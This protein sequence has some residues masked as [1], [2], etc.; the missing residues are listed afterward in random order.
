MQPLT[1]G[2][3]G[4]VIGGILLV[5][6]TSVPDVPDYVVV[7][8]MSWFYLQQGSAVSVGRRSSSIL[9]YARL[10]GPHAPP[11]PPLSRQHRPSSGERR[12]GARVILGHFITL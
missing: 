3:A 7:S 5:S 1:G 4:V 11:L 12:V 6:V 9:K 8:R 2:E 10:L